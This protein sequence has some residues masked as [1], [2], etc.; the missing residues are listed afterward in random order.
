[1]MSSQE[2]ASEEPEGGAE[3]ETEQVDSKTAT[4]VWA[5]VWHCDRTKAIARASSE[6]RGTTMGVAAGRLS[7]N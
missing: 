1:M 3:D 6:P 7:T 2:V 5:V 4:G